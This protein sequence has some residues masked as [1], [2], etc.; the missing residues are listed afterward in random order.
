MNPRLFFLFFLIVIINKA[1]AQIYYDDEY[2]DFTYELGGSLGAMNAFTDIGG[3]DGKGRM[4]IKDINLQTTQLSYGLFIGVM[5]KDIIG[6]RLEGT[7]GSVKAYDSLL[8]PNDQQERYLRNLSFSSKIIELSLVGEYHPIEMFTDRFPIISPYVVAGIGY[9][10]FNPQAKLNGTYI[11]LQPL[12]TEG[13]GFAEY[14]GRK[15]Y[16]LNQF[17]IPLG[18]GAKFYISPK[19]NLKLEF[20]YR[21]LFTDYLDDASTTYI[22]PIL[23]SKYLSG[24]N[25]THALLLN[26]RSKPGAQ[27]A[28]IDGIRA[29]SKY[30]DAYYT[31]SIKFGIS[32][33]R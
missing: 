10:H 21:L 9:Y 14:P 15:V 5:Y 7:Y 3:R 22:D 1:D 19:I 11:D 16:S 12:R 31:L 33:G 17:N 25:L 26:D 23:F 8:P 4:F 2:H 30:N 18:L 20:Q 13:Q 6:L 28:H 27:T 32:L 24:E 29:S